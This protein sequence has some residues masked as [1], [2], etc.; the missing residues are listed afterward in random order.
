MLLLALFAKSHYERQDEFTSTLIFKRTDVG[1]QCPCQSHWG[2]IQPIFFVRLASFHNY[3]VAQ[4]AKFLTGPWPSMEYGALCDL[5]FD[6]WHFPAAYT[7]I[8]TS[9]VVANG[10]HYITLHYEFLTGK[11]YCRKIKQVSFLSGHISP[12]YYSSTTLALCKK[13]CHLGAFWD[14]NLLSLLYNYLR[15]IVAAEMHLKMYF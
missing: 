2:G 9:R 13:M 1:A 3:I 10:L 8:K 11:L 15:L 5:T 14:T 6:T 12:M 4:W 7:D